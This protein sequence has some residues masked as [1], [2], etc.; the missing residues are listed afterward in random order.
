M[1]PLV[2]YSSQRSLWL[3]GALGTLAFTSKGEKVI[4]LA[5]WRDLAVRIW[6]PGLPSSSALR[7]VSLQGHIVKNV[8]GASGSVILSCV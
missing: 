2:M 3:V 8:Q 5:N 4:A 7:P 1:G 6:F